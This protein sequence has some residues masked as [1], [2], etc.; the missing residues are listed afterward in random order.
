[1]AFDDDDQNP[2]EFIWILTMMIRIPMNLYGFCPW[3]LGPLV[4]IEG[5]PELGGANAE[6]GAPYIKCIDKHQGKYIKNLIFS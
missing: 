6:S 4:K 1:M 5:R 2:Y 3:S